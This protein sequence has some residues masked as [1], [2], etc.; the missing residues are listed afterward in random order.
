MGEVTEGSGC[1]II[2]VTIE[3]IRENDRRKGGW[4]HSSEKYYSLDG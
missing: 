1:D 4:G 2:W 3:R